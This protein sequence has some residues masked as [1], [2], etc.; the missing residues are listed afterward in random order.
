MVQ[1][2]NAR[3]VDRNKQK[4]WVWWT[5]YT[6]MLLTIVFLSIQQWRKAER[7]GG[8]IT[9]W[10]PQVFALIKG[11]D[12]YHGAKGDEEKVTGMQGEF[13]NPPISAILQVPFLLLSAPAAAVLWLFIKAVLA[14]IAII[15]AGRIA[16]GK[17]DQFPKGSLLIVILLS[18]QP[19]ILDLQH[20]N[21]NTI[22]M[23]V[24]V[25][26]LWAFVSGQDQISGLCIGLAAAMKVTPA[27]FLI[28]FVYKREWR[29]IVWAMVGLM[30][31]TFLVPAFVLGPLHNA[32]MVIAWFDVLIRP[33]ALEGK[34]M[35]TV[36]VNQSIPALFYRLF[37]NNPG[38]E[39]K[40]DIF[41]YI[42]LVSLDPATARLVLKIILLSILGILFWVC[43]TPIDDRRDWRWACEFGMV[44]IVMVMLSERSWKHHY[45][46]MV[47]PF[48]ALV[49]VWNTHIPHPKWHRVFFFIGIIAFVLMSTASSDLLRWYKDGNGQRYFQAYGN[50]LIAVSLVFFALSVSVRLGNKIISDID[51]EMESRQ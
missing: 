21:V 38:I 37:T 16:A 50:Y 32:K 3:R 26:G 39:A 1:V 48:A 2:G 41:L 33:Y 4:K 19:I 17:Y 20:G 11:K 22:V 42:N 43:R 25:A 29:T 35:Y 8:A 18:A 40:D 15:W 24:C 47:M 34:I 49:A 46:T 27:L 6:V 10:R 12:V 9:R 51:C 44:F 13:P 23:F 14:G 7:G 28:Y 30:V 36:H 45:V 31:F 5:I